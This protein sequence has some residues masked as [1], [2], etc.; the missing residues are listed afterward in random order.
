MAVGNRLRIASITPQPASADA[1]VTAA[2]RPQVRRKQVAAA[3]GRLAR[4]D[5]RPLEGMGPG[6]VSTHAWRVG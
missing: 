6:V 1:A 5:D 2:F 3:T 4:Q